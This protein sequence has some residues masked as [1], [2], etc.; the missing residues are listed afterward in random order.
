MSIWRGVVTIGSPSLGGF[1][2]NTWHF[3]TTSTATTGEEGDQLESA[4]D[5]L[6]AFYDD[7]KAYTAGGTQFTHDGLW[8]QVDDDTHASHDGPG[9]LTASSGGNPLPPMCSLV[10]GWRSGAGDRSARGRTFIGPPAIASLESNGTP[11]EACRTAL[12]AAAASLIA[13]HDGSLN[14]QFVVW[15]PQENVGRDFTSGLVRNVFGSL[16]SRRD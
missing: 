8:T 2:S 4:T 15:S 11:E 6:L 3:R 13:A 12:N 14:G 10:I 16:R 7:V 9:W 1:G 5:T